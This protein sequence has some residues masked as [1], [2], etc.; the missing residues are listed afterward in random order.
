MH[1]G[2]PNIKRRAIM[3]VFKDLVDSSGKIEE[4]LCLY[5]AIVGRAS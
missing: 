4:Q 2:D 1:Y 5:I 3:Q